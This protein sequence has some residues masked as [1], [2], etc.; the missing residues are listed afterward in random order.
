MI[1]GPLDM[2]ELQNMP[3]KIE[4]MKTSFTHKYWLA[5]NLVG[6]FFCFFALNR[7]GFVVFIEATFVFLIIN[8]VAG[9][10]RLKTIPLAYGVTCIICAYVL[11]SSVLVAPHD[12]HYRWMKN[13]PRMLALVFGMHCL[14]Q[15]KIDARVTVFFAIAVSI[16]VCWQFTAL[17]FFGMPAGTFTGSIHKLAVFAVLIIPVIFYFFWVTDGWYRYLWIVLGLMAIDLLMQTGS[18]PAFLGITTGTVFVTI[19][20]V[21]HRY[22]WFGLAAI[23]LILVVLFV[24]DYAGVAGRIND[25]I[26]V[27][28]EEERIQL[29]AKAWHTLKDNSALDWIFGNGIGY[30]RVVYTNSDLP[31]YIFI[32]PHNYILHLVYSSGI[33][34]FLLVAFGFAMLVGLLFKVARKNREKKIRVLAN[35]LIVNFFSWLTLCGLNF[36]MYSKYSLYPLA[37]VLGPMLVVIQHQN[38]HTKRA[39]A[40]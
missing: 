4:I 24:T 6:A 8:V 37:F 3:A 12:S 20:L 9:R 14:Y 32:S 21:K 38:G 29:W 34:G 31:D 15:K 11:L 19:F 27:W 22:K 36:S 1:D 39:E 30:F 16:A 18:R 25:F 23:L 10:Y 28:R 7:G 35:C 5:V 13:V 40:S 2:T 17:H 33:V 26:D